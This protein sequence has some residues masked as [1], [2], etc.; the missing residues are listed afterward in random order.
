MAKTV[1]GFGV[2]GQERKRLR[3]E[4]TGE[5]EGYKWFVRYEHLTTFWWTIGKM[6]GYGGPTVGDVLRDMRKAVKAQQKLEEVF[7]GRPIPDEAFNT[8]RMLNRWEQRALCG[9]LTITGPHGSGD[10]A[11]YRVKELAA[12]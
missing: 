5:Y 11:H 1:K 6:S 9:R 7:N 3:S 2:R 10:K 12:T 4:L 8:L